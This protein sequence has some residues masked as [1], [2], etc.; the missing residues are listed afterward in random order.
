MKQ[1]EDTGEPKSLPHSEYQ[2]GKGWRRAKLKSHGKVT[3]RLETDKDG[4][5]YAGVDSVEFDGKVEAISDTGAQMNVSGKDVMQ[6]L[7]LKKEDLV[8]VSLKIKV[9]DDRKSQ[10]HSLLR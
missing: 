3:I 5:D 1:E 8:N 10:V 9:A 2:E 6:T 7:K 4:Y